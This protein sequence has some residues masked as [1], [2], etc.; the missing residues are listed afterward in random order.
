MLTETLTKGPHPGQQDKRISSAHS[1]AR[2]ILKFSPLVTDVYFHYTPSQIMLA[3]LSLADQEL[4][5]RVVHETFH[6][7]APP[8]EGAGGQPRESR[9][10]ASAAGERARLLGAEMRDR[11][12]EAVRACREVLAREPP[13]RMTSY[14]GT[15]ES[16]QI[17]RPLLRKLK[18]CRDPDRWDLVAYQAAKREQA[19]QKED[20]AD[21]G[22]RGSLG[23]DGAVFGDVNGRDVKRRKVADAPGDPFGGAL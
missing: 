17:T 5:E 13:E 1:R 4:A 21:G 22:G 3:A 19:R 20:A 15:P 11:V 18:K 14:W 8:S 10:G 23:G 7:P 9:K 12:L 6:H 16:H 2:E